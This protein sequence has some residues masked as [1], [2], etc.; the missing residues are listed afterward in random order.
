MKIH[1]ISI[2]FSF[3]C[4]S[5]INAQW[6]PCNNGLSKKAVNGIL[7][8]DTNIFIATDVG[9]YYSSDYGDSWSEKNSGIT[10]PGISN[11]VLIGDIIFAS[12]FGKGVFLTTDNGNNWIPKNDSI[13]NYSIYSMAAGSNKLFIGTL[14]R[15]IYKSLD[16]GN[17]WIDITQEIVSP[18]INTLAINGNN[19]FVGIG[20]GAGVYLSTDEGNSWLP[21]GNGLM[22]IINHIYIYNDSIFTASIGGIFLSVDSGNNWSSRNSGLTDTNVHRIIV[23]GNN[24]FAGTFNRGIYLS[25]DNG[26]SWAIKNDGLT[27]YWDYWIR[28]FALGSDYIFAG[29][30]G[31]LFRA[32]LSD[33]GITD[34]KEQEQKNEIKI[35]PNPASDE[36]R[37]KFSYPIET[38]VQINVFDLLGNYVLSR[39][40]QASEG[41]NEKNIYCESMPQG[42]YYVK[43][44][45]NEI[46]ETIPL[47]IVK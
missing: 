13:N 44:N 32:R 6:M 36:F 2:L 27:N 43:I 12:T 38:I 47:V 7:I 19:L 33:F 34:V 10:Y 28:S 8:K 1:L 4:I 16:S 22:E 30:V 31:G 24:L 9:V 29:T 42:Y 15:G 40:E 23:Y 17:T 39:T 35:Y 18:Y 3:I 25:T 11:L 41:T 5:T 14:G 45:I 26:N 20:G 37:L 21:K 46:I